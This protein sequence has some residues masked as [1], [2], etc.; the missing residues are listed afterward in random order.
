MPKNIDGP[1]IDDAPDVDYLD[2]PEV[3]AALGVRRLNRHDREIDRQKRFERIEAQGGHDYGYGKDFKLDVRVAGLPGGALPKE[4]PPEHWV[5]KAYNATTMNDLRVLVH[6]ADGLPSADG[7]RKYSAEE[8]D[9]LLSGLEAKAISLV[10]LG[11]L[12][13]DRFVETLTTI[14]QLGATR[15]D[16]ADYDLDEIRRNAPP[17]SVD[18]DPTQIRPGG[19]SGL[20]EEQ[21]GWRRL[22][23]WPWR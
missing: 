23:R 18:P 7:T 3:K 10:Y 12:L 20:P 2:T 17:P 11:Q 4:Y 14:A 15:E 13:G 9:Q 21:K 16:L 22:L 19:L 6:R 5:E 1:P 8:V